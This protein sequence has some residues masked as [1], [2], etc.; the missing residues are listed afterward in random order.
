MG[1]WA[2]KEGM[3]R[4]EETNWKSIWEKEKKKKGGGGIQPIKKCK[5]DKF[6]KG[7]TGWG[8]RV[9]HDDKDA[10]HSRKGVRK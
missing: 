9:M 2:Q 7:E 10:W 6:R 3:D 8:T 5:L 4:Y 1:R